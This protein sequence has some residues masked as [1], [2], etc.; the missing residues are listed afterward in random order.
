MAM[1]ILRQGR[2]A[3]KMAGLSSVSC[4][5]GPPDTVNATAAQ[6]SVPWR[7]P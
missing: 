4:V 5:I 2:R 7:H 3:V 6:A 1:Y